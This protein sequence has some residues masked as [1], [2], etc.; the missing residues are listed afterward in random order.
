M[1]MGVDMVVLCYMGLNEFLKNVFDD[2]VIKEFF[3]IL[4]ELVI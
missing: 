4:Y 3:V 2:F 1:K